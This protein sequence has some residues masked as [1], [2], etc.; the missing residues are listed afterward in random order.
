MLEREGDCFGPV[1]N[2][3]SRIVG[4]A[5]PGSVVVSDEVHGSCRTTLSWRGARCTAAAQGHRP[6]HALERAA[7]STPTTPRTSFATGPVPNGA[8]GS[9]AP[10][11]AS[12]SSEV[13][14]KEARQ[15]RRDA[16]RRAKREAEDRARRAKRDIEERAREALRS[17][18]DQ[19]RRAKRE[20]EE[21]AKL[22][23]QEL[24][25]QDAPR[26]R[27]A[28]ARQRE[29]LSG[30]SIEHPTGEVL[31]WSE[32]PPPPGSPASAGS[33]L[34]RLGRLVL[35]ALGC[36][37]VIAGDILFGVWAGHL[38][39]A[40]AWIFSGI[41]VVALVGGVLAVRRARLRLAQRSGAI[42]GAFVV[43]GAASLVFAAWAVARNWPDNGDRAS[44][45]SVIRPRQFPADYFGDPTGFV[46]SEAIGD[47]AAPLGTARGVGVTFALFG[48]ELALLGLARDPDRDRRRE[49][50]R[51]AP[52]VA[53]IG[54][55][56]LIVVGVLTVRSWEQVRRADAFDRALAPSM[57]PLL[58][59]TLRISILAADASDLVPAVKPEPDWPALAKVCGHISED[60]AKLVSTER[61]V[62]AKLDRRFRGLADELVRD[63]ARFDDACV[64]TAATRDKAEL[65]KT[66]APA[67]KAAATDFEAFGDLAQ[68]R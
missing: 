1:V 60:T 23:K 59:I 18:D 12:P 34:R 19:A 11:N 33:G 27:G 48:V 58:E 13:L 50:R 32:V 43:L 64:A 31:D 9:S 68:R 38:W 36:V 35:A 15:A 22:A 54:A 52:A 17:V 39:Q 63:A 56:V 24:E 49:V 30:P 46:R 2:L 16:L 55:T 45:G 44:C 28:R 65:K 41:G 8:S 20:V 14:S 21:Q 4:I 67:V 29:Q 57:G 6:G 42:R 25:E 53:T 3:A 26:D 40:T 7:R 37:F 66:L 47:C 61:S 51:P 10:S 62:R 5:F